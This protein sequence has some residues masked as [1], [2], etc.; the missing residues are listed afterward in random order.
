MPPIASRRPSRSQTAPPYMENLQLNAAVLQAL[1][2]SQLR[3]ICQSN[4]LPATGNRATLHKRLKDAGITSEGPEERRNAS[5]SP[6]Q[7]NDTPAGPQRHET[8]SFSEEQMA[9][10]KRLVQETVSHATREIAS[11][12]A[13]AAVHAM[14]AQQSPPFTASDA[15]LPSSSPQ[16]THVQQTLPS[17]QQNPQALPPP[18]Q[19]GHV[20]GLVDTSCQ[21]G[22]PFQ[23]I[24]STYIK[25]IQTGEFFELS[26][27]LPKNLSMHDEGDNLVLSLRN[28]V[29]VPSLQTL[30]IGPRRSPPTCVC[31]HKSFL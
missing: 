17:P 28:K 14:R 24:P 22:A 16:Q 23:D 12:A 25:D 8:P 29:Q 15:I 5:V 18:Q 4:G 21:N 19:S 6:Q 26:K 10:I 9:H 27:L 1:S 20:P 13:R 31:S 11:E 2:L 7:T 3:E 30:T